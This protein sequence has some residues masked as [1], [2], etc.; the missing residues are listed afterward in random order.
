[1]TFGITTS[2]DRDGHENEYTVKHNIL[3]RNIFLLFCSFTV[4]ILILLCVTLMCLLLRFCQK[5]EP[6]WVC[7]DSESALFGRD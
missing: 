7:R 2:T 3:G 6:V 4:A 1:M 5:L